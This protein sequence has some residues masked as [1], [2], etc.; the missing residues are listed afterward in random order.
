MCWNNQMQSL[1]NFY[2]INLDSSYSEAL[3][4]VSL[5][6]RFF[7]KG[8]GTKYLKSLCSFSI[9]VLLIRLDITT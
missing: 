6:K 7:L 2:L 1:A 9:F 8:T 3:V 4:C 5:F